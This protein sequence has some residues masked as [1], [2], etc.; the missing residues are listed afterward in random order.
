MLRALFKFWHFAN[1][2]FKASRLK[3][4][5]MLTNMLPASASLPCIRCKAGGLV[6]HQR[7]G[8]GRGCDSPFNR[9]PVTRNGAQTAYI[10]PPPVRPPPA[11]DGLKLLSSREHCTIC[12]QVRRNPAASTSVIFDPHRKVVL[13]RFDR[14][15]FSAIL[16]FSSM[17]K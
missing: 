12:N 9:T 7:G 6:V 17:L 16:A 15:T 14:A 1:D 5:R 10:P 4:G 11:E 2:N 3:G 8:P 13:M